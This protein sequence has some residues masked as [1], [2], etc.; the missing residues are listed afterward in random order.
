MR[1]R[2]GGG[3]FV[4][5]EDDARDLLDALWDEQLEA[6]SVEALERLREFQVREIECIASAIRELEA[7]GRDTWIATA[8][9]VDLASQ[10]AFDVLEE[11]GEV[12]GID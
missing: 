3:A 12:V 10:L 9:V 5:V 11:L 4:D 1:R 7:H 8:I 6:A 2:P